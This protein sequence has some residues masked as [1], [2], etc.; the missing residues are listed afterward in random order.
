MRQG[1]IYPGPQGLYHLQLNENGVKIYAREFEN[2]L[3]LVNPS[4][5]KPAAPIVLSQSFRTLEGVPVSTV[6]LASQSG[7][8]LLKNS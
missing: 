6:D 8:I 7:T 1:R 2:G 3:V 4:G 5:A